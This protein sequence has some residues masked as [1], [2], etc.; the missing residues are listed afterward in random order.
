MS[1]ERHLVCYAGKTIGTA[2][3][4]DM[5]D[6]N[7]VIC[8]DFEPIPGLGLIAWNGAVLNYCEG[9]IMCFN[10]DGQLVRLFAANH[11]LNFKES[12]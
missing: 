3:G 9:T 1:E 6:D 10:D 2:S 4:F 7:E 11:T 5:G 12:Q 8:Y